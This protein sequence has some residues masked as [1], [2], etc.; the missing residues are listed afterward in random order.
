MLSMSRLTNYPRAL[1]LDF[2]SPH[3]PEVWP[4]D[5]HVPTKHGY[6]ARMVTPEQEAALDAIAADPFI[7]PIVQINVLNESFGNVV[8]VVATDGE[9]RSTTHLVAT[10]G[11]IMA[12]EVTR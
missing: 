9:W 7:D 10:D 5:T 3:E 2:D 6:K 4:V 1:D 8:Q 12:V 11:A